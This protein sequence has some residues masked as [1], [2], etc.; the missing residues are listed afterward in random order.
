MTTIYSIWCLIH[1]NSIALVN[2][3]GLAINLSQIRNL[4]II[5]LMNHLRLI[6]T[7]GTLLALTYGV[8]EIKMFLGENFIHKDTKLKH[9]LNQFL[10]GKA[11]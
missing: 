11:Q 10:N 3:S 9:Q 2:R 5:G 1:D 7:L 6:F 4:G 8:F